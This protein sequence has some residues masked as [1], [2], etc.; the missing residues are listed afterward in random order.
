[1]G[2][3]SHLAAWT[4]KSSRN[5]RFLSSDFQVVTRLHCCSSLAPSALLVTSKHKILQELCRNII[6]LSPH[7]VHVPSLWHRHHTCFY[8]FQIPV[9]HIFEKYW[10]LNSF[11]VGVAWVAQSVKHLTLAQ[12]MIS[13]SWDWAPPCAPHSVRSLL[14]PLPFPHRCP[15]SL[16]LLNKKNL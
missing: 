8:F 15:C 11:A 6:P 7:R 1:M 9:L 16:S 14:L 5:L 10:D 4:R 12:V 3:G 2:E 13:G